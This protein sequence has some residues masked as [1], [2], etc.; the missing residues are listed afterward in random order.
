MNPVILHVDMDAFYAS[1][2]QRDNPSLKGRP[3]IVGGTTLRGVAS[4]ASY[5]A[6][7]FGVHSAMP[8]YKA[9]KKCPQ[10]IFLPVRMGRYREV[11]GRI[12]SILETFSPLVEQVSIDEAYLDISGTRRLLGKP[13][14]IGA[15]IK[16]RVAD[17]TSLSCSVG[18]APNKFLAKIASEADKPNG[19]TVIEPDEVLSFVEALPVSRVPG[20]G[21]KTL[22]TLRNLGIERLGEIRRL[23]ER[24]PDQKTG[25]FWLKLFDFSMGI[26][27][28]PV[29]P[30]SES[31]SISSEVTLEEDTSDHEILRKMILIQSETVGKRLRDHNLKASTVALKL[32]RHDFRQ[33]TRAGTVDEPT[34]STNTIYGLGLKLLKHFDASY[35][36]RLVG[37]GASNFIRD[38]REGPR[39]LNLFET[40]VGAGESWEE[41][42]KAM[43]TIRDRFGED[44]IKRGVLL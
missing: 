36:F 35:K 18:I 12:M 22:A 43:D 34:N 20:V 44:A 16:A 28:S 1:V 19:L 15:E 8:L 42:E 11:S 7:E 41:V 14:E 3:V 30:Y 5:E 10:G 9:R 37:V 25:K 29:V 13:R 32:K 24:R 38:H 2:E 39:Q 6:R 33:M 26:D 27:E 4:A 21:E 17:V 40:V 31:K 23:K